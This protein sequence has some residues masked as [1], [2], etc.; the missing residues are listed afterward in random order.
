MT[1]PLTEFE[2]MVA[3]ML[4]WSQIITF[5]VFVIVVGV[6]LVARMAA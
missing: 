5:V 3:R 6:K 4:I 1:G 2:I